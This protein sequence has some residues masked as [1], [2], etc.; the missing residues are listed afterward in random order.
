MCVCSISIIPLGKQTSLS[1]ALTPCLKAL[2]KQG[3]LKYQITPMSTQIEGSLD[4]VLKAVKAMHQAAFK[5]GIGRV[6]TTITLDDRRDK[7]VSLQ[8]KVTSL[9]KK[10]KRPS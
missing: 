6:Y 7:P 8:S 10:L 4:Q 2:A 3:H 9:Q 1:E 5:G